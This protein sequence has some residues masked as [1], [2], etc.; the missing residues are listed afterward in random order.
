MEDVYPEERKSRTRLKKEAMAMQ[1]LGE[2]LAELADDQLDRMELPIELRQALAEVKTM[3]AHGARRRQ[4]QYIGGIMRK[5][6]LEPIEQAVLEIEQGALG[7]ARAFQ[8]IE[9]WRDRLV[10]G[11][12]TAMDEI[13]AAFPGADRQRLGQLVRSARKARAKA[14]GSNKSARHLFRYIR[15]LVD[16]T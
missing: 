12:D 7:Q 1:R 15:S 6:D 10:A 11:E 5:V 9:S 16:D 14:D 3:H 2:R 13:L 8:R 4:M